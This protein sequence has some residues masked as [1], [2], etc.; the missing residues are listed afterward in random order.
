M[1]L[2]L[3]LAAILAATT[4]QLAPLA[5]AQEVDGSEI[6]KQLTEREGK[7]NKL[8]LEEQL[9]IRAAQ[10]K[11]AEDPAIKAALE[12]RTQAIDEFRKALHDSM[13]K[14]DP[15]LEAILAK[16]A[17]GTSPGF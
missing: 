10:Q 12:K 6:D 5:C 4:T 2:K 8:T 11:A 7:I 3:C 17:I 13:V 15:A 16:I 9:K 14:A 1:K